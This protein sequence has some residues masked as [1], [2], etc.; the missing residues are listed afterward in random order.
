M[1]SSPRGIH[2]PALVPKDGS[3][4]RV[5]QVRFSICREEVWQDRVARKAAGQL[6]KEAS[7]K[8]RGL[9]QEGLGVKGGNVWNQRGAQRRDSISQ[10]RNGACGAWGQGTGLP[11]LALLRG[12]AQ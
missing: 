12:R 5:H 6:Q 2:L 7:N 4:T 1:R 11:H 3:R 8:D 9:G 10:V